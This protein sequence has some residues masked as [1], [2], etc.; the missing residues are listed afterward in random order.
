MPEPLTTPSPNTKNE[1]KGFQIQKVTLLEPVLVKSCIETDE[2]GNTI[3][4][5]CSTTKELPDLSVKNCQELSKLGMDLR[6][7]FLVA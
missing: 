3:D 6:I 1:K 4:V 5:D 2:S 7:N